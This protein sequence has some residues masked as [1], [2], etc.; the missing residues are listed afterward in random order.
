MT[1]PEPCPGPLQDREKPH[2]CTEPGWVMVPDS[3][4]PAWGPLSVGLGGGRGDTAAPPLPGWGVDLGWTP[5]APASLSRS[6]RATSPSPVQIS[7]MWRH[8]DYGKPCPRLALPA[9]TEPDLSLQEA[10]R[11]LRRALRLAGPCCCHHCP[12]PSGHGF[13]EHILRVLPRDGGD[14]AAHGAPELPFGRGMWCFP[15]FRD[16]LQSPRLFKE[17]LASA[18][19]GPVHAQLP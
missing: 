3:P 2:Y 11:L 15:G 9:A 16:L 7:P 13:Q 4:G 14:R 19:P 17:M 1:T 12:S 8:G 18:P 5:G 6:L 10:A